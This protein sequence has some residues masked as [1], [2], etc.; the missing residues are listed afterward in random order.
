MM[1]TGFLTTARLE[2]RPLLETDAR[3]LSILRSDPAVNRYL[4]RPVRASEDEALAFIYK[5]KEGIAAGRCYYWVL[6]AKEK[7]QFLG[8]ICLWNFS[9]EIT[10]AETGFE[11]LPAFQNK[12]FMK[13]ALEAVICFADE[14]LKLR[15]LSAYTHRENAASSR[16]LTKCGFMLDPVKRNSQDSDEAIY[17]LP[18]HERR[19]SL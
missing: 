7:E 15:Q 2:L 13:E 17:L 14:K 1:H 5:I 8:T 19:V 12:G 9:E 16:L 6:S 11:L 10:V 3:D 4:K 18:L